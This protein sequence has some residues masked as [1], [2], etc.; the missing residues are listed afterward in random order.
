MS[1]MKA[2]RRSHVTWRNYVTLTN[3]ERYRIVFLV[4]RAHVYTVVELWHFSR[5][6]RS[7]LYLETFT[8]SIGR[9]SGVYSSQWKD[10]ICRLMSSEWGVYHERN[11]L[12]DSSGFYLCRFRGFLL[13]PEFKYDYNRKANGAKRCYFLKELSV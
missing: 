12:W 7:L 13:L 3:I 10:S 8:D 4:P 11:S 2:A 6:E 1:T 9:N 5:G